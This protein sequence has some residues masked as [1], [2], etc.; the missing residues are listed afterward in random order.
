ML[1]AGSR[2]KSKSQ[3]QTETRPRTRKFS[4]HM[5][6][7]RSSMCGDLCKRIRNTNVIC[8]SRL[9][10]TTLLPLKLAAGCIPSKTQ[11]QRANRD[12]ATFQEVLAGHAMVPIIDVWR[13]L[14]KDKKH[15]RHLPGKTTHTTLPPLKH[16]AGCIPSKTQV[17]RANR[18]AATS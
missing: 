9:T 11:V 15:Q 18:G 12:A 7:Y 13:F 10:H 3:Q 16:A 8:L 5:Q 6:W 17:Q 2:V 1:L 4:Q 14:Q